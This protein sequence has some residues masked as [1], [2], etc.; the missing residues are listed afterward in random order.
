MTTQVGS[1]LL[2]LVSEMQDR[3]KFQE[4]NWAGTF[5]EYLDTVGQ[6]PK[7]TRNAFQ[8]IYDMIMSYGAEEF[9]DA[10]KRLIRY[11]FFSDMTFDHND[12]IFGL[13]I[14]LMRLVNFFKAA[15][16]GYGT[17]KRVLL[18]HGPVGSSKST[19]ARRL[20]KGLEHYSRTDDGALY[21]FDWYLGDEEEI[22]PAALKESDWDPCPMHE[23]P[24]HLVPP[25]LRERFVVEFNEGREEVER[26]RIVGDL[27]PSCRY[28]YREQMLRY[29]GDW[30]KMIQRIRVRRLVFSE[31][32]RV[33]IG[34]FQP[35]PTRA[36]STSMESSISP[37]AV[38]L[39]SSRCSSSMWRSYTICWAHRR[40]TRSSLRSSRRL[41]ST[42]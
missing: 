14:P 36:R 1:S 30:S 38:S 11:R 22:D 15:S 17:E 24:L 21:T 5:S 42:K 31:Q 23:E 18:L 7:V 26:I 3:K 10:K 20:K 8:R 29:S 6:N 28:N 32:D 34:T 25:E 12:A 39:S 13:E 33:G 41:I 16:Q 37:T 9:I 4:L 2:Q 40:S 35:I 27:C 19:I